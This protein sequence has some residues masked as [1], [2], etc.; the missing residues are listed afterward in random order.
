MLAVNLP[1]RADGYSGRS[2]MIRM[3]SGLWSEIAWII[4]IR[5]LSLGTV[6]RIECLSGVWRNGLERGLVGLKTF[7]ALIEQ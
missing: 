2:C 3:V 1:E 4:V 5:T 7:T 6:S